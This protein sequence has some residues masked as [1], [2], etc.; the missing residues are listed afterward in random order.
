MPMLN[1]SF[2]NAVEEYQQVNFVW[3]S[4]ELQYRPSLE[5]VDVFV[6]GLSPSLRQSFKS[7]VLVG[8]CLWFDLIKAWLKDHYATDTVVEFEAKFH[9][10]ESLD[11]LREVWPTFKFTPVVKIHGRIFGEPIE[12]VNGG[13]VPDDILRIMEWIE[14]NGLGIDG[15]FRLSA[16]STRLEWLKSA[17]NAGKLDFAHVHPT[18]IAC[19]LKM[20]FRALPKPIIDPTVYPLLVDFDPEKAPEEAIKGLR[21]SIFPQMSTPSLALLHRL[22]HLLSQV[23]ANEQTNRMSAKNLAICWAPNLIYDDHTKDQFRL[24]KAS[25]STVEL[26]IKHCNLIFL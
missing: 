13:Q 18:E 22:M 20:Y 16:D 1:R 11:K 9:R 26:M 12:T 14:A 6:S 8:D 5:I 10:V 23:A 2:N 15:I 21:Q 24:L 7:F 3:V 25:L 4:A 17:V 19:L